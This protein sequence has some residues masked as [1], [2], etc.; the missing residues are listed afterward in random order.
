MSK[1]PKPATQGQ[2]FIDL[3][4]ESGADEDGRAFKD[5]LRR[6]AKQKPVTVNRPKSDKGRS[7]LPS[8]I[9]LA[10]G[11]GTHRTAPSTTSPPT[12]FV[13]VTVAPL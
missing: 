11:A 1:K 5:K 8:P 6:I 3:A 9:S 10:V 12:R 7:K 2:K 13:S 4:R